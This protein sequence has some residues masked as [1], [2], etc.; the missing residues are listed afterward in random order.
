M[1]LD[2]SATPPP[3]G[4]FDTLIDV[5]WGDLDALNHVNNAIYFRYFEEARVHLY[6]AIDMDFA[7]GRVGLLAHA[8]CDFL[9]P[10]LY[11]ARIVVGL[12]LLRLGRS[13]LELDTRIERADEPGEAYAR[14]RN[15]LVCADG[16]TGR[17]TPWTEADR[18]ALARCF[19]V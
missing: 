7:S 18:R 19:S 17:P 3:S 4:T 10:L 15:V 9:R 12:K 2:P 6:A 13:S 16:A 1:S 5:R 14:G 11:P 8:S